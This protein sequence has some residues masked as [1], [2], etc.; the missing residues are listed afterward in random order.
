MLLTEAE[1]PR[2][3]AL[4]EKTFPRFGQWTFRNERNESYSGFCIWGRYKA[5]EMSSPGFFVTFD[6]FKEK[7]KGHLTVGQH[8]YYWSS[9]D[10]GDA[11]LLDTEPCV[12]LQEAIIALKKRIAGL[13]AVLSASDE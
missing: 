5:A 11:Y 3:R 7:W 9:A 10:V 2:C 13:V 1:I 6:A 8:S 4:L 12:S